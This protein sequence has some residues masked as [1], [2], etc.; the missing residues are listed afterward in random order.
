MPLPRPRGGLSSLRLIFVVIVGAIITGHWWI[1]AEG[2][3]FTL[4]GWI[5]VAPTDGAVRR[6]DE[7]LAAMG[8]PYSLRDSLNEPSPPRST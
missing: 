1:F 5:L 7:E 3:A 2:F 4:I 6:K 8:V